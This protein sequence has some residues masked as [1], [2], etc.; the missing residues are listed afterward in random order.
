MS[1]YIFR[2]EEMKKDLETPPSPNTLEG[3]GIIFL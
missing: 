2:G 3:E 1:G